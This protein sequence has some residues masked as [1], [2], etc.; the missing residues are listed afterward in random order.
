MKK[1]V[2]IAAVMLIGAG[3]ALAASINVPFFLDTTPAGG[4]F[5]PQTGDMFFIGLK[6]TTAS[7]I[8]LTIEYR[9]S[10]GV[11]STGSVGNVTFSLNAFESIS[12]RPSILDPGV[13]S[14]NTSTKNPVRSTSTAGAATFTWTGGTNDIQ[15]RGV[16]IGGTNLGGGS[17]AFLLPPGV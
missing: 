3:A 2:V 7:P 6:N 17:F 14:G 16:Q 11:I 10:A 4:G 13:E 5:P 8:V 15:G 9:D 1:F 12:Y